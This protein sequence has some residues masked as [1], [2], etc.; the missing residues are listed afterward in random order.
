MQYAIWFVLL[1]LAALTMMG[2]YHAR[3][4]KSGQDFALAGRRLGVGVLIGTLVATWIGTGSIF[5]N[6]EKAYTHGIAILFVPIA[7]V[8]GIL[9]LSFLAPRVREMPADS[10]PEMLKIRFGRGA[11]VLG[12]VALIA[13]YLVIVS[14]QYRAGA[15]VAEKLFPHLAVSDNPVVNKH[16]FS[17]GFAIF[18]ILYTVLAGMVSVAWTDLVNGILMTIGLLLAL[19]FVLSR[20]NMKANPLPDELL[21]P[22]GGMSA[23]E[24]ISI[25]LPA[26]LLVLGD[27]NLYQRFM[28]ARSPAAAR[29][30]AVGMFFGVMVLE[31]VIILL[32]LAGRALLGGDL[33]HPGHVVI[34]LA[35]HSEIVPV[36][37]GILLSM[38]VI[39]VIV[40]TADSYLL[41]TATSAATD[42][43]GGL[44]S[45]GKQRLI[46][47]VLGLIALGLSFTSD[48]FFSVAI[49]AY[50]LYGAV[51]TPAV[52]CALFLPR[53]N[54][55]A[56]LSAMAAGLFSALAWKALMMKQLIPDL[57]RDVDAVLPALGANLLVLLVLG[58]ILP[59]QPHDPHDPR[60][61]RISHK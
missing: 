12:A 25:T 3:Q 59:T 46:V 42:L 38:T 48:K 49:Y 8:L 11:Q 14:Y 45:P 7:G 18:V 4:I 58:I 47:V 54:R 51:L 36:P 20:W 53:I 57:L 30:A 26:L 16:F 31:C 32:A 52:L 34:D 40:T 17:V 10:V 56:I 37:V 15:A 60:Q 24:W 44:T 19:V 61:D 2:V 1:F 43:M 6:A 28:S 5:G 22:S 13:S 35:F 21:R 27:A 50:T 23:L 9:I 41:G 29:T 39:A 33:P 55:K